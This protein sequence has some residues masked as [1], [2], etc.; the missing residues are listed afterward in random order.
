LVVSRQMARS[1][2]LG[3]SRQV[4]RF[5]SLGFAGRLARSYRVV[6]F[7]HLARLRVDG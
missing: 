3:D 6:V 5:V 7:R 2:L 4:A 1:I